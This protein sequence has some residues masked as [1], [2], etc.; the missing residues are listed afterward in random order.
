MADYSKSQ[1]RSAA[2]GI[3]QLRPP[4][5]RDWPQS[6]VTPDGFGSRLP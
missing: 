1:H 6:E 2:T 4:T 3:S 5:L